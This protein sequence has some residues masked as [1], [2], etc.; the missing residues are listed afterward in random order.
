MVEGRARPRP[1]GHICCFPMIQVTRRTEASRTMAFE[2]QCADSLPSQRTDRASAQ[3]GSPG[4]AGLWKRGMQG[5]QL[6][7]VNTAL[8]ARSQVVGD[9]GSE[10]QGINLNYHIHTRERCVADSKTSFSVSSPGDLRGRS[11]RVSE[12]AHL[13]CFCREFGTL[14]A[15]V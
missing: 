13:G 1:E 7:N 10:Q 5:P 12:L 3:A 11:H 14:P 2:R 6:C 8:K 15:S 9:G 4:Q